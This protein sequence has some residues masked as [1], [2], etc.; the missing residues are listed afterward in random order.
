[1]LRISLIAVLAIFSI[2]IFS[3][4][5]NGTGRMPNVICALSDTKHVVAYVVQTAD[6][7]GQRTLLFLNKGTQQNVQVGDTGIIPE[8]DSIKFRISEVYPTRS[9][10][11]VNAMITKTSLRTLIIVNKE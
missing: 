9:K 4:F 8:M 10:A 6:L 2:S 5:S 3:S 7:G 11:A 1:M